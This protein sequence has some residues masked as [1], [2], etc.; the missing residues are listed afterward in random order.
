MIPA[1]AIRVGTVLVFFIGFAIGWW[2]RGWRD[3]ELATKL[4]ER[5]RDPARSD[6]TTP[7]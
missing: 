2:W 1:L 7:Q 6:R 3:R 5:V 4:L